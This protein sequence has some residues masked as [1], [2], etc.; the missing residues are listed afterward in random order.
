MIKK[1]FWELSEISLVRNLPALIFASRLRKT[2]ALQQKF[3]TGLLVEKGSSSMKYL[4]WGVVWFWLKQLVLWSYLAGV[5]GRCFW[6][7]FF[8]NNWNK[9][10]WRIEA[11]YLCNP[12]EKVG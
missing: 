4:K 10:G 7:S 12:L 11:A 6:K 8:E 9:F 5:Y 2:V 1:E 3:S